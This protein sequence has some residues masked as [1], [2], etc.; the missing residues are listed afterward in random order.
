MQNST[1]SFTLLQYTTLEERFHQGKEKEGLEVIFIQGKGR[2]VITTRR[3]NK[4]EPLCEYSGELLTAEEGVRREAE[5]NKVNA[6][7]YI[8]YFNFKSKKY[9]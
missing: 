4:G 9:W 5:Y 6:G 8:Y 7:S 3:F 2:A 1:D